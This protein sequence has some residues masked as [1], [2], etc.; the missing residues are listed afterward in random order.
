MASVLVAQKSV[1]AVYDSTVVT[2]WYYSIGSCMTLVICLAKKI[3]ASAYQLSTDLEPWL[4]LAYAAILGT[5]F[6]YNAYSWA[7][8]VVAPG[9][10]SIYSTLQVGGDDGCECA[11]PAPKTSSTDE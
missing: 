4:A 3:D 7:G 5:F 10:I 8:T 1:L 6:N 2:T 11:G 9:V